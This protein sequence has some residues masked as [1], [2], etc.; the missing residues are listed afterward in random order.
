MT[1]RCFLRVGGT[2]VLVP[3]W[4]GNAGV[5]LAFGSDTPGANA[6]RAVDSVSLTTGERYAPLSKQFAI[7]NK[8]AK[9]THSVPSVKDDRSVF[10]SVNNVPA[11]QFREQVGLL[12]SDASKRFVWSPKSS[13]ALAYALRSE[14]I[15]D[16]EVQEQQIKAGWERVDYLKKVFAASPEQFREMMKDDPDA[17]DHLASDSIGRKHMKFFFA[18]PPEVMSEAI[19]GKNIRIPVASMPESLRELLH[20]CFNGQVD[21]EVINTT[22]EYVVMNAPYRRGFPDLLM[23]LKE[24][25]VITGMGLF[26]DGRFEENEPLLQAIR[27]RKERE[28]NAELAKKSRLPVVTIDRDGYDIEGEESP[29]S[30]YLRSFAKQTGYSVYGTWSPADKVHKKPLKRSIVRKPLAE[31]LNILCR[32]YKDTRWIADETAVRFWT[33]P[34][35]PPLFDPVK[36][37]KKGY[38]KPVFNPFAPVK[39][40][41]DGDGAKPKPTEIKL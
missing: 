15:T 23:G 13:G 34:E 38:I 30:G 27:E 17:A 39:P 11:G 29:L 4:L 14:V 35:Q 18:L 36:Q 6:P 9:T 37:R 2:A 26:H 20:E 7:L 32:Y 22:G 3:A 41:S 25:G 1:R 31:A 40:V 28:K 16:K 21:E 8:T 12:L 5:L 19:R 10:L 24:G 33:E